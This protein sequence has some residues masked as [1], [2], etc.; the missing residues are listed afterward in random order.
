MFDRIRQLW[1][2]LGSKSSADEQESQPSASVAD[3]GTGWSNQLAQERLKAL[4]GGT[5]KPSNT[6]P[7]YTPYVDPQTFDYHGAEL[8]D[9]SFSAL[10]SFLLRAAVV[11]DA[12]RDAALGETCDAAQSPLEE[13][14]RFNQLFDEELARLQNDPEAADLSES[15]QN[16][17]VKDLTLHRFNLGHSGGAGSLDLNQMTEI[18]KYNYLHDQILQQGGEFRDGDLEA[19]LI[20]M[21]GLEDGKVGDNAID[22]YNDTMFMLRTEDG[23]PQVYQY[24]ASTDPGNNKAIE[25]Y[26]YSYINHIT[27][28]GEGPLLLQEGTYSYTSN[29]PSEH[30]YGHVLQDLSSG[31]GASFGVTDLNGNR[32]EDEGEAAYGETGAGLNIHKGGPADQAI[33][34]YSAG[35]QIIATEPTSGQL[36]DGY[37]YYS[38]FYNRLTEDPRFDVIGETIPYTLVDSNK[39]ESAS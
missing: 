21:R 30:E 12:F 18:E 26:E 13:L 19:N 17:L 38:S 34:A 10:P 36:K 15:Q 27:G 2:G 5:G 39:A 35:C 7:S 6:E 14:D 33:N 11:A 23:T 1:D 31:E 8:L 20:G 28:V 4:S 32:W 9:P 22:E 24:V 37:D 29:L 3:T 16:Q 25:D